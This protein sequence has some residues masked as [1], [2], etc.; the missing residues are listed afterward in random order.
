MTIKLPNLEIYYDYAPKIA[1]TSIKSWLYKLA[2]QEDFYKYKQGKKVFHIHNYLSDPSV[3]SSKKFIKLKKNGMNELIL[4]HT[5]QYFY[6]CIVRDPIKKL[7]SAYSN[8]VTYHKE[9]STKRLEEQEYQERNLKPHPELNYFVENLEAYQEF[10]PS[11]LRHTRPMIDILNQQMSYTHVYD[12]SQLD[13][14]LKD[15]KKFLS[16]NYSSQEFDSSLFTELPRKQ[17]GGTKVS[18]D[19]L[20]PRNFKKLCEYYASDYE[21]IAKAREKYSNLPELSYDYIR[22]EY[23]SY[24]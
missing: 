8:R 16:L 1:S 23:L 22:E 14:L 13:Y 5:K 7:L 4:K 17:T 12:I 3:A 19:Y 21:Y 2:F 18:L 24:L 11:I 20:S 15:V 6:F 10:N 9:L